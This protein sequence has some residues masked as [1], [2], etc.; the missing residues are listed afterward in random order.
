LHCPQRGAQVVC[1]R[2]S[3][4]LQLAVGR[5]ELLRALANAALQ[6]AVEP[7]DFLFRLFTFW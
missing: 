2:I 3:E 4:G 6:L 5:L 1:H 7:P